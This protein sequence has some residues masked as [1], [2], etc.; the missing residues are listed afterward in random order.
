MDIAKYIGLFLL[1]NKFCY[2]HGLGNLQIHKK[3]AVQDGDTLLAPGYEIILQPT[4]S[5]DDNLANFIA[6]AEQT[7]I[8]KA[9][10]EIRNF[11]EAAR[12]ELAAGNTVAIPGIGHFASQNGKTI[13]I[14]DP[15]FSYTPAAVPTLKMSKRLEE[16]PSFKL[17]APEDESAPGRDGALSKYRIWLIILAA[18]G[19]IGIIVLVSRFVVKDRAE[20]PVAE[21]A[22]ATMAAPAPVDTMAA[23]ASTTDTGMAPPAAGT[24]TVAP[25]SGN[26]AGTQIILRTYPTQAAADRRRL[27]LSKTPLGETVSVVAR[28]SSSYLVVIPYPGA[29]SDSARTLDSLSR[30][31]GSRATLMQR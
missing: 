8:S 22:P 16:A 9:S 12:A 20:A 30:L 25:S 15:N 11:V 21:P 13:F 6:T 1:K 2:L 10:T 29:L 26:T 7:S 17:T 19:L 4:G 28:D 31:Y 3:P 14:A 23:G 18:A 27:Q 5:I 24:S